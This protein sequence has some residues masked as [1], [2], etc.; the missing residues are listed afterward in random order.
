MKQKKLIIIIGI[1]VVAVVAV[2]SLLLNK[3]NVIPVVM[4]KDA[5]TGQSVYTNTDF[6]FSVFYSSDWQGPAERIAADPKL[7][8]D[9]VNAIFLSPS[10][11][12]AV[13]I[14]GTK[15]DTESFN[16]FAAKLDLPSSIVTV[17]GL[18]ALRYE[19]IV[20][21]NENGTAYAKTVIFT[22]KGLKMGSVDIA[23]QGIANTEANAKLLKLN[24][25]NDLISHIVFKQPAENSPQAK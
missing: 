19:Y 21:V 18:P 12:E 5:A 9:A 20:P 2:G 16:D 1:A 4:E 17:G 11:S 13:V 22:L 8:D 7:K 6:D 10:S 15:G 25:L 24:K 14:Q 3:S 23:Y